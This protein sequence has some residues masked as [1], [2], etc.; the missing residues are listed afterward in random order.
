VKD[1]YNENYRI[2]KKE[3]EEDTRRW[4]DLPYSWIDRIYVVKNGYTTESDLQIQ[5]PPKSAIP[6]KISVSFFLQR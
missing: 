3:I 1:L 4:K 2:L 6:S 5:F